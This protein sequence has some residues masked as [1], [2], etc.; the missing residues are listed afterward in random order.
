MNLAFTY[1]QRLAVFVCATE[2]KKAPAEKYDFDV[3]TEKGG[4]EPVCHWIYQ[5][6]AIL[7]FAV[8][9]ILKFVT[10]V[11]IQNKDFLLELHKEMYIICDSLP[12]R[13]VVASS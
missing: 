4:N 2:Q 5:G 1:T 3:K 11:T 12:E 7:I 10:S 9:I 13:I 6:V 8:V